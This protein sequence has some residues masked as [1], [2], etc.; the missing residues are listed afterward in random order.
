MNIKRE[1]TKAQ[2]RKDIEIRFKKAYSIIKRFLCQHRNCT[3]EIVSVSLGGCQN[4][5]IISELVGEE[6]A[7]KVHNLKL[8][9]VY[10]INCG[11]ELYRELISVD[12]SDPN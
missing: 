11:R 6:E 7:K 1:L 12:E 8:R 4:D 9:R 3:S 2:F 5:S 10:C